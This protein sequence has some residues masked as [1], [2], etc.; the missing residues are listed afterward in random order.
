MFLVRFVQTHVD[1]RIPELLSVATLLAI[2][3]EIHVEFPD[4]PFLIVS[5]PSVSSAKL[6][7]D[8]CILI[9]DISELWAYAD[10]SLKL[11]KLLENH[12][13]R[14]K[15]TE[16]SFKF[17]VDAYGHSLSIEEQRLKIEQL[18]FMAFKGIKLNNIWKNRSEN[19][20][21]GVYIFRAAQAEPH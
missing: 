17:M 21:R 10:S 16:C 7:A 18:S 6:I 13:E 8:R 12:E 20:T 4:S 11:F 1:F 2:P 9:K 14:Q 3:L 15:Y 19:P 5:L